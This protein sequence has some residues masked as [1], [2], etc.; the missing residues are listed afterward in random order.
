MPL[1]ALKY[2]SL[3]NLAQGLPCEIGLAGHH[4]HALM[5]QKSTIRRVK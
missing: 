2:L 1:Q 5:R 4:T 3:D